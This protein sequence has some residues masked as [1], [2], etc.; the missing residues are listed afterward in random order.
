VTID[1][2]W[3]EVAD[4]IG[5]LALKLKLHFEQASSEAT[6]DV[7]RAVDATVDSIEVAFD[8]LRAATDD[9]AIREDARVV[10]ASFRDALHNTFAGLSTQP[11]RDD[12]S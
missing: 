3:R 12:R 10:A 6:A 8:G 7:K 1:D 11:Q 9:P 2:D 4:R 5:G